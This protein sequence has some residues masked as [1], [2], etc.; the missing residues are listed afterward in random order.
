MT[1]CEPVVSVPRPPQHHT[2]PRRTAS[3]LQHG[4]DGRRLQQGQTLLLTTPESCAG[5]D[6]AHA[7]GSD[8]GTLLRAE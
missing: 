4:G 6:A 1:S 7:P 8:G 2:Y 3:V 5:A